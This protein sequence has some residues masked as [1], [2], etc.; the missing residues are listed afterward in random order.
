M[1]ILH[2]ASFKGNIGD[3]AS[4]MGFYKI[5]KLHLIDFKVK[6]IEIRKF[7]KNYKKSDALSFDDKFVESINNYDLCIIGG[8]GFLD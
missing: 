4:H 6:K 1:K 2:V 7:Y 3:N 8:G 5:L